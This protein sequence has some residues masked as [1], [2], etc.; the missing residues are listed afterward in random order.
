MAEK[1]TFVTYEDIPYEFSE[2]NWR[3]FLDSPK[4]IDRIKELKAT[5]N[6]VSKQS[7]FKSVN[8][9][10]S[11]E[12][13]I[14]DKAKHY[15]CTVRD[16]PSEYNDGPHISC[17]CDCNKN[18]RYFWGRFS[19]DLCIHGY[20]L[21]QE[22][23]KQYGKI[24]C[25][26]SFSEHRKRA[27]EEACRINLET[28][29]KIKSQYSIEPLNPLESNLFKNR[30]Q[31]G[32]L[33]F[34]F[35][36][37][38]ER[39]VTCR[40]AIDTAEKMIDQRD[41]FRE[42]L[43]RNPKYTQ[44]L[45][46]SF[47]TL[48]ATVYVYRKNL[49][50]G[51]RTYYEYYVYLSSNGFEWSSDI[52]KALYLD[53]G[54]LTDPAFKQNSFLNEYQLAAIKLLWDY[55]DANPAPLTVNHKL[56]E[57][58][59]TS[60]HSAIEAVDDDEPDNWTDSYLKDVRI[61]PRITVE[62]KTF[63]LSFRVALGK[64]KGCIL[65]DFSSFR[66][67]YNDSQTF[68]ASKSLLIDFSQYDFESQSLR[69]Y[70]LMDS[71][72]NESKSILHSFKNL[73]D[74]AEQLE[75]DY[76]LPLQGRLLDEFYE[77]ACDCQ[78][79]VNDKSLSSKNYTVEVGDYE[80]NFLINIKPY[81]DVNGGF[82]GITVTGEAPRLLDG[83]DGR[84]YVLTP[85]CFTS[86]DDDEF[87][88]LYPFYNAG[89]GY[90]NFNLIIVK[91]ELNDFF[92]RILPHLKESDL[93]TISVAEE[94]LIKDQLA[95]E[96][97]FD[98]Y[99]LIGDPKKSSK[100]ISYPISIEA[101]ADYEGTKYPLTVSKD[102]QSARDINYEK[103]ILRRASWLFPGLKL[104]NNVI[105][106]EF[107]EEQFC[108]FISTVIPRLEKIGTVTSNKDLDA[109]TI[110]RDVPVKLGISVD[111][112]L[113]DI[114]ITSSK[115][116]KKEL[117]AVLE[118]Y[119][120]KKRWY[121]VS[122][123]EFVDLSTSKELEEIL[124]ILESVDLQP[125]DVLHNKAKL[126]LF[127]A[128]YLDKLMSQHNNMLISRD[129]TFRRII[130]NFSSVADADYEVPENLK[131]V[132]REYQ[133]YGYKWLQ[134]I[135]HAGFGAIL[136]DDM[137]L[138]KTVQ[139]ITVL[140]AQIDEK[141]KTGAGSLSLVVSPASLVYQ[142]A[143]EIQ[144]FSANIVAVPLTGNAASRKEQLAAPGETNLFII[145]YELLSRDITLMKDL[146]FDMVILDEAQKIKNHKAAFT[147]AV[148]G[149][150]A[151]ARI[152]LTGTPI[153]NRL[154]ELWSIFDFIMPGF[155]YGVS[156]FTRRFETP[157]SKLHDPAATEKL[158]SMTSPFILRR[159]KTDVLKD[160]PS[161]M[162]EVVYTRIS[163]QQQKLYDAQ[164]LKMKK[165][166][167]TSDNKGED[168][169]KILAELMRIRQIC[170]DPSL[171]FEDYNDVSAKKDACLDLI[172]TA[173]DGNH[174]CLVFS[175][176]TSMLEIL[177]KELAAREISFYKITGSTPKEKRSR[178][179][180]DFN[181][182]NVPV[183]LISLKAGGTGLNLV[184]ADTVIHY[185]PWWNLAAQNQATDRAHRIG[186][187]KNVTVYRLILKDTIEEKILNL[188]QTKKDL[189][190]AILEGE[191]QSL[192][193]LS[194]DELLNLLS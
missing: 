20:A 30:K 70:K 16:F 64:G 56:T 97:T 96:P 150:N 29:K 169:I 103:Q 79:D 4:N 144:K 118:S 62:R 69:Y 44:Y 189:A 173:I 68:A 57:N 155:L 89:G 22:Y 55:V 76:N 52:D 119:T 180:H 127:R 128:L 182:G 12:G 174:R 186:Q 84:H 6:K 51:Y 146:V 63:T 9:P 183:F 187:T 91:D 1:N 115:F 36:R 13:I 11:I 65:K 41:E 28:L 114:N 37:E 109:Y 193:S 190:D 81:K 80:V 77:I 93:F 179:V 108:D 73:S 42:V 99:A 134:I 192:M 158:K 149:L 110:V 2:L 153:E 86:L 188:Q 167:K 107:D 66:S 164:V 39:S 46:E 18:S 5:I 33:I 14:K 184:G 141:K 142:W 61:Y 136:A 157:I 121:K 116:N 23:E 26:E 137:G 175:Q 138:G 148:K 165:I 60:A 172:E 87:E 15:S 67:A 163:G 3:A 45:N 106:G 19:D 178:L 177:E 27:T 171:V 112:D 102:G 98:F 48:S 104:K 125:A 154:T 83:E 72:Y 181:D 145:S 43:I 50:D 101:S 49:H 59:M 24:L 105:S 10:Y 139:L 130:R 92:C 8:V 124:S 170:C 160:L 161:K 90:D 78:A 123:T 82:L 156:D 152:A 132:L 25:P 74:Y 135:S 194:T 129:Q 111:T 120:A 7:S 159:K 88:L 58:F 166:I 71:R 100:N 131:P 176:F 162:E 147:K 94:E 140:Q 38:L 17:C 53:Y 133:V 47:V 34:D 32:Y 54:N 151:K 122:D 191:Q 75:P 185:D 117:Q 168:K 113:L 143:E 126:P 21:L 85:T 95:P 40:E 35:R 31:S